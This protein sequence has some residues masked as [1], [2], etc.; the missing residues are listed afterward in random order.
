MQRLTLFIGLPP[1][2]IWNKIILN[3]TRALQDSETRTRNALETLYLTLS[4]IFHHR[5]SNWSRDVALILIGDEPSEIG[6]FFARLFDCLKDLLGKDSEE[7]RRLSI[8]I[9][10]TIITANNSME[11]NFMIQQVISANLAPVLG[12]LLLAQP[13]GITRRDCLA[14]ITLLSI[15]QEIHVSS[16]QENPSD[17]ASQSSPNPFADMMK[18]AEAGPFLV[19]T[20]MLLEHDIGVA[21]R[22]RGG[23]TYADAQNT[24]IGWAATVGSWFRSGSKQSLT[25]LIDEQ[26]L[27][28]ANLSP[29]EC[30]LS[31]PGLCLLAIH[32]LAQHN[33]FFLKSLCFPGV[34][35]AVN[36]TPPSSR[37][38]P[39]AQVPALLVDF[40]E[41]S[42]F[43]LPS[44]EPKGQVYSRLIL[45]TLLTIVENTEMCFFLH[46]EKLATKMSF[47]GDKRRLERPDHVSPTSALPLASFIIEACQMFLRYHYASDLLIGSS[48][49]RWI[50]EL[51]TTCLNVLHRLLCFQKK[52]HIRIVYPWKGLWTT[53]MTF[54]SNFCAA[55]LARNSFT[56]QVLLEDVIPVIRKVLVLFNVGITFGDHFLTTSADYDELYY[57]I[58]RNERVFRKIIS[59]C[60]EIEHRA[61]TSL[62][63]DSSPRLPLSETPLSTTDLFNIKSILEHFSEK[64]GHFQ[65][66]NPDTPISG[67]LVINMI[68][69]NYENLRL[70][71]QDDIDQY[72]NYDPTLI[73]EQKL[74]RRYAK[75]LVQD[76]KLKRYTEI[77]ASLSQRSLRSGPPALAAASTSN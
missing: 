28:R 5:F 59:S 41:L 30:F 43:Y 3:C 64:L 60:E 15:S 4:G 13:P 51:F 54:L 35:G 74:L 68:K 37:K 20:V 33:E 7:L 34:F 16:P 70:K 48:D 23:E 49:L 2:V 69:S 32:L 40:V 10:T 73:S 26:E 9:I 18:S 77:E 44:S 53:L 12:E 46:D 14:V 67:P 63:S 66:A 38:L 47:R 50:S 31:N 22:H 6:P 29:T 58:I 25:T 39:L 75:V 8:S 72:V 45:T 55:V 62:P 36:Q 57:E 56:P 42:S 11:D 19:H 61:S 17:A 65:L 27:Q 21:I 76:L 24:A 52:M 71:L 1:Q